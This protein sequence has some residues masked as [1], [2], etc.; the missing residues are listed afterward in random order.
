MPPPPAWWP[1]RP[2]ELADR[3]ALGHCL[4]NTTKPVLVMPVTLDALADMR[5]HGRGRGGGCGRTPR[6]AQPHRLRRAG[7]APGAPRRIAPQAP[8]LR[9][10]RPAGRVRAL[11]RARRHRAAEPGRDHRAALRRIAQRAGRP[12]IAPPRRALHLRRHGIG[13]GHADDGLQLRRARVPT[14][15]HADGRDGAPFPAAQLRHR[16]DQRRAMLRRA[17]RAW[18]PPPRA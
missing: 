14:G 16:G 8:L 4:V 13:D 1:T 9:R 15:Q 10:S 17:G 11:R 3:V 6:A 18:R 2:A 7:V 5:R 12:P